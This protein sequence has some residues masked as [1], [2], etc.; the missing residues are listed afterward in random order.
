MRYNMRRSVIV[1]GVVTALVALSH[2]AQAALT[3]RAVWNMDSLPTMVDSAG[4][5]NNGTTRN[6]KLSGG[7]YQFNGT[8]SIATSPDKAN[9]DPGTASIRL[10]ARIS[11]TT[12]PKV[13]QTYDVIRKGV[14]TSSGGYYKMEISRSGSG[15]AV[16]HCRFK[17]GSGQEVTIYSTA[18]LQN[19]GFVAITCTKTATD[20]TM[21]VGGASTKITKAIGSISNSAPVYVGGKGDGTDWFPGW[22][23]YVKID[24]G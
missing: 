15:Q 13:G 10:S 7:A 17:S 24:I 18:S 14:T 6:I 16:A 5:D 22:M 8:S 2:P 21:N 23:D 4:G 20:V 9:L 11:I 19:K 3:A 1:L 12:V